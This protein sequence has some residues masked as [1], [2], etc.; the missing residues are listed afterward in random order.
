M[1][2]LILG[3]GLGLFNLT[4]LLSGEGAEIAQQVDRW[5]TMRALPGQGALGQVTEQGRARGRA[6]TLKRAQ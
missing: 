1:R 6:Q 5:P 2:R 4:H 3:P